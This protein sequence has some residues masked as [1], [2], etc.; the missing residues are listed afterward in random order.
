MLGE[1]T[2][3][4]LKVLSNNNSDDGMTRIADELPQAFKDR[5]FAVR[6]LAAHGVSV[7]VFTFKLQLH[8]A[9]IHNIS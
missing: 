5:S 1:W 3:L 7:L 9:F 8:F 4:K 6:L 2:T